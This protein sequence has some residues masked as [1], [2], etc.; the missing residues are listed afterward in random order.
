MREELLT[1]LLLLVLL[2]LLLGRKGKGVSEGKRE[3]K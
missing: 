2:L 1:L 3:G